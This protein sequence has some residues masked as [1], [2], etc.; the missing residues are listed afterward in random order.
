MATTYYFPF[1]FSKYD[2]DLIKCFTNNKTKIVIYLYINLNKL[3]NL[4][5]IMNKDLPSLLPSSLYPQPI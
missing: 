1:E 5:N 4:Y 3:Y 2:H